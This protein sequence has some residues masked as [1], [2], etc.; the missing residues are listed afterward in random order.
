MPAVG[1]VNG[2]ISVAYE[3]R[4]VVRFR[5]CGQLLHRHVCA[6]KCD[7]VVTGDDGVVVVPKYYSVKTAA[8]HNYLFR[9]HARST[10]FRVFFYFHL[11][12]T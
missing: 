7:A 11:M 5:C 10:T 3:Y 12:A 2:R 6:V 9:N 1:A 4:H 8:A